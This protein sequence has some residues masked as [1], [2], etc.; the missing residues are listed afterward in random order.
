MNFF[1]ILYSK[2][3]SINVNTV[4]IWRDLCFQFFFSVSFKFFSFSVYSKTFAFWP[5][6]SVALPFLFDAPVH[7]FGIR[8]SV[9]GIRNFRPTTFPPA[10]RTPLHVFDVRRSVYDNRYFRLLPI[11]LYAPIGRRILS[12]F[13]GFL[14]RISDGK[15]FWVNFC[16]IEFGRKYSDK[17]VVVQH[18]YFLFGI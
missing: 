1:S 14:E 8:P 16:L 9:Y 6:G 18:N 11:P 7:V 15:S 10:L 12:F 17:H 4:K 2:L 3:Y 5:I 13:G